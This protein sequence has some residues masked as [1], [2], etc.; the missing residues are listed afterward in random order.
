MSYPH[1]LSLN[2]IH[3]SFIPWCTAFKEH[4]ARL[5]TAHKAGKHDD[6]P[7]ADCPLCRARLMVV[8]PGYRHAATPIEEDPHFIR[9]CEEQMRKRWTQKV[10][11]ARAPADNSPAG[12]NNADSQGGSAAD[13]NDTPSAFAA[14]YESFPPL[15][16]SISYDYYSDD[17]ADPLL[18]S[19]TAPPPNT[20]RKG[21]RQSR[22]SRSRSR[23]RGWS[24]FLR[25]GSWSRSG[26]V[27]ESTPS[28]TKPRA[29][30]N[31]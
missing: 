17:E 27:S 1:R 3:T 15:P 12:K 19:A 10:S 28:T 31:K 24:R 21:S 23:S 26:S 20:P 25:I 5:D 30:S 8:P 4:E 11:Q 29:R 18:G 14:T 7:T 9:F 22:S 6:S 13:D 2:T 16:E